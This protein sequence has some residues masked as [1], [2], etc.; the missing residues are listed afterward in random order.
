MVEDKDITDE[1][2]EINQKFKK[3]FM[4]I[5]L[6][7]ESLEAQASSYLD[8]IQQLSKAMEILK[9]LFDRN[10]NN[11]L[12]N[13]FKNRLDK[14]EI[15][16][17][18]N[19]HFADILERDGVLKKLDS[20]IKSENHKIK[21]ISDRVDNLKNKIDSSNKLEEK[22]KNDYVKLFDQMNLRLERV[23]DE[24]TSS[25]TNTQEVIMRLNTFESIGEEQSNRIRKQVMDEINRFSN[26]FRVFIDQNATEKIEILNNSSRTPTDKF[27]A[28]DWFARN[29]EL[30]STHMIQELM[31]CCYSEFEKM[32]NST[33]KSFSSYLKQEHSS[34]IV[35]TINRLLLS[36]LDS[37]VEN[38]KNN[39]LINYLNITEVVL[40]SEFNRRKAAEI[41]LAQVLLFFVL[42]K[43]NFNLLVNQVSLSC[44][45]LA[46]QDK[47]AVSKIVQDNKFL[48]FLAFALEDVTGKDRMRDKKS[49]LM[50]LRAAFKTSGIPQLL[51]NENDGIANMVILSMKECLDDQ[52]I[53]KYHL[54]VSYYKIS[55]QQTIKAYSIL[56]IMLENLNPPQIIESMFELYKMENLEEK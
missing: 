24:A 34:Q 9:S 55:N 48:K 52:E 12:M 4:K 5:N 53:I 32:S 2:E 54:K 46:L 30:I 26:M 44:V 42:D 37:P 28:L 18:K 10:K 33:N 13:G 56:P 17:E 39:I 40:L 50:L 14:L 1:I 6:K 23:A 15:L 16:N 41:N 49:I 8:K 11:V 47:I 45:S 20:S 19:R 22:I 36:I 35:S 7:T 25:I 31:E 21:G 43:Q 27:D 29:S 51:I 38:I 3:E